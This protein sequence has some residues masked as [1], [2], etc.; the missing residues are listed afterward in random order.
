MKELFPDVPVIVNPG[1]YLE[2]EF[3]KIKGREELIESIVGGPRPLDFLRNISDSIPASI[4]VTLDEVNLVD[5]K[6]ARI[7]GKVNTYDEVSQIEKALVSSKMFK[8][9]SQD[10]TGSALKGRIQFQITAV[11]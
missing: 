11:L 9:V 8:D 5:D 6:S 1:Q 2:I 10:T 4:A 7:S 3:S